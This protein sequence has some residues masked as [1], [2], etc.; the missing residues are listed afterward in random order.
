ERQAQ[1][2]WLSPGQRCRR[3]PFRW[4]SGYRRA[5]LRK[6]PA[7]APLP[8]TG[9]S[10]P[11]SLPPRNGT[12]GRPYWPD[13]P[14]N[15]VHRPTNSSLGSTGSGTVLLYSLPPVSTESALFLQHPWELILPHSF[16]SH[17]NG[18]VLF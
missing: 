15:P 10:R 12:R 18:P 1:A 5:I 8:A 9:R 3:L 17:S 14:P 11:S 13:W 4:G 7:E 16:P 6:G 2:E